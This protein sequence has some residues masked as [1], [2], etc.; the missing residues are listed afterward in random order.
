MTGTVF[1]IKE[2]SV[3]DG[4][5]SR[6]TVFL[7]GCPLRCRWCHNPEGLK[8]EPQI[9]WKESLCT[10]CGL[11]RKPCDH[12]ECRPYGR[13]L[14]RC[15]AGALTVSGRGWE[16]EELVTRLRRYEDML[17]AMDGGITLSG[18]EPMLQ[19]DFAVE[20]LKGLKGI[21][22]AVQTSGFTDEETF[23]RVT[24]NLEYVMMDLKLADPKKHREYTGE[25][26]EQILRNARILKESGIPHLFRIPLIPGIT[27]TEENLRAIAGIAGDSPVELLQYNAFAPAKYH[28][29]NMEYQLTDLPERKEP[30]ISAFKHVTV[31]RL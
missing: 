9:M 22:R 18:G 13:C 27:D 29:L 5:G 17:R 4:P 6:V 2:F 24:D 12:P 11:C 10:G 7:K 26:N 3:H 31:L 21:H 8:A 23:K 20:V 15:T 16:A 19:A 14:K 1:D 30:D 25:D 28:M